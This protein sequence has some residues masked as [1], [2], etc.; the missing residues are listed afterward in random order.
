MIATPALWTPTTKP[1][2]RLPRWTELFTGELVRDGS[3]G[4]LLRAS[5]GGHLANSCTAPCSDCTTTPNK[6]TATLSGHTT[7][8]G[9]CCLNTPGTNSSKLVSPSDVNGTVCLT[10]LSAHPCVWAYSAAMT[11][12]DYVFS[13]CVGTPATTTDYS[14]T[15]TKLG[16]GWT[17]Q[18]VVGLPFAGGTILFNGTSTGTSACESISLSFT[19]TSTNSLCDST[20][21][22]PRYGYGGTMVVTDGC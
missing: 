4:H 7:L 18:V 22:I 2:W 11:F 1:W 14:F 6:M 5:T 9:I 20:G 15:L 19:N 12:E 8:V 3:T 16:T 17:A 13:A 21:T 10:Q